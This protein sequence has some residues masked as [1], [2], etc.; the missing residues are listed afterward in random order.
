MLCARFSLN[1]TY[2]T[3]VA[4]PPSL[5]PRN[6]LIFRSAFVAG[7]VMYELLFSQSVALEWYLNYFYFAADSWTFAAG[8]ST[9][10]ISTC[11]NYLF[12]QLDSHEKKVMFA[13]LMRPLK[14][15]IFFLSSSSLVSWVLGS[16]L[17]GKVKYTASHNDL[18]EPSFYLGI[19]GSIVV[20]YTI[21]AVKRIA[22][23]CVQKE[24]QDIRFSLQHDSEASSAK[25]SLITALY[26]YN[27]NDINPNNNCNENKD[28]TQGI[29]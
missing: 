6:S 21:F 10:A 12:G 3:L 17:L 15:G 19:V 28:T 20:F 8:V 13:K 23:L 25:S 27:N 4:L 29:I 14:G 16:I 9:V 7:N 26:N 24:E 1:S 2:F 22:A 5:P 11:V 18:W